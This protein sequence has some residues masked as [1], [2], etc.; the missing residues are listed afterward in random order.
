MQIFQFY[1]KVVTKKDHVK[2][3]LRNLSSRSKFHLKIAKT[4]KNNFSLEKYHNCKNAHCHN[5]FTYRK[6][7]QQVP[8][9]KIS[10]YL[11]HISKSLGI[12]WWPIMIRFLQIFLEVAFWKSVVCTNFIKWWWWFLQSI[13]WI[14][15]KIFETNSS[16]HVK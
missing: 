7:Q 10:G 8:S 4:F 14:I 9:L 6:T 13:R 16:F 11:I 5:S 12:K 2:F 3:L 1:V 15:D